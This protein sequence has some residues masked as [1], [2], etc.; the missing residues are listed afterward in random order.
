VEQ[1]GSWNTI[2]PTDS[3]RLR[4]LREL[5]PTREAATDQLPN[6]P[7]LQRTELT[8]EDR[9]HRDAVDAARR[10]LRGAE[11][12]HA[13][14]VKAARRELRDAERAHSSAVSSAR[15]QLAKAERTA[16]SIVGEIEGRLSSVSQG[17]KLAALGALV[18][19]EDRLDTSD[20]VVRLT[21]TFRAWVGPPGAFPPSP[22]PAGERIVDSRGRPR[23]RL[24][25]K[26]VYLALEDGYRRLL[27]EAR[28][29]QEARAFA[30]LVNVAALNVNRVS[31]VR[32]EAGVELDARLRTTRREQ[33]ALVDHAHAR[34]L[35]AEA[36]REAVENAA[37]AL[38]D[39]EADT[40]EVERLREAL[41]A[42]ERS[43]PEA[44]AE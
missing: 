1:A 11:R 28:D 24:N 6:Q 17:R 42:V 35:E 32:D 25:A 36:D 5:V 40:A 16:E 13:S 20:E 19:Y 9:A 33:T 22:E 38:A 21:P 37:R 26:R 44:S 2:V 7:R 30:E 12:R 29:E 18:L 3:Q 10:D 39:V 4:R 27:V 14:A 31:R 8:P 23:R 43:G 15:K 34:L 41:A